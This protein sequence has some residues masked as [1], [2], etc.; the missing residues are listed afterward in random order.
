MR[1]NSWDL[2]KA[3]RMQMKAFIC[4]LGL[5]LLVILLLGK[6]ILGFLSSNEEPEDEVHIPVVE[7]HTNVWIMEADEDGL[8]IYRDGAEEQYPYG[9]ISSD[10]DTSNEE[11]DK[12]NVGFD[13]VNETVQ[14]NN[15]VDNGEKYRPEND[16]REQIADI[17]LTDGAVTDVKVKSEKIN[18][19]ILS[20]DDTG[21]EVEGYGKI[22]LAQD[23]KGYRIYN[24]LAMC[25]SRDLMIG[26]DF[27]D[28]VIEDGAICG[29][30]MAREEAMESIR[31]LL[32]ASDYAGL[33]HEQVVLTSDTDF[34]I[35]YGRYESP[36]EEVHPAGE[37]IV[38]GPESDFFQAEGTEGR[39]TVTPNVLTGK[40]ILKSVNRD[41]CVPAYRGHM[42]L[43]HTAEGI[44]VVNEVLLE[45]YLYCVV[46]SEMPS[47]YPTEALKVQAVCARTYAY[48][49]MMK[50]GYPQYGA[51]VDD[52][53]SYQV[54]NNILEQEST[55]TAVKETYGQ[56]LYTAEGAL[57]G[58]FY[59]STSCGV[60]S[61]ANVWKTE[62]A[63]TLKYLKAKSISQSALQTQPTEVQFAEQETETGSVQEQNDVQSLAEQ[64]RDEEAFATFITSKNADDYEVSEGWYRWTYQVKKL[65]IERMCSVMKKRYEA[66]EKLVLT[67]DGEEYVQKPIEEFKEVHD[68]Y[69]AK[70]G[71][72]GIADEMVIV[73]ENQTYKVV[74]EH[75]IRYIL[76][77]GESK[78]IRQDGS[79]VNAPNILPSGFF[80]L[81]AGKE[82]ENVVGYTLLGGGFGHGVGMSQNG[83]KQM[84]KSGCTSDDILQ[85][86]YDGCT[87]KNVYE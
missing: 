52:S 7:V 18:G 3:Q 15:G 19:R 85:F 11:K 10:S 14:K 86:F 54:Y 46:P 67:L 68:L 33:L 42:E 62:E 22:P 76:N 23:Y 34:T 48:G 30:L 60:G 81:S 75:N 47:K 87:V 59:Y 69:I 56:L 57:A 66:N 55:T 64:L 17:V 53:T 40:I 79:E 83:A 1:K 2:N 4:I 49:H 36:T 5:L 78:V 26:Y 13:S 21:V 24:T 71:L 20:A 82:K 16:V 65:D 51:H 25:T 77:D 31:V 38:I 63:K 28:L 45:E 39:V 29:L 6:L 35:R 84:A 37:E 32:K 9:K 72:G 44:A 41:Q 50:A 43:L 70:R 8:M 74:S 80:I 27:A 61:D 12:D 73:T 58:T